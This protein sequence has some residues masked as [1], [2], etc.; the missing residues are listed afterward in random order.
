MNRSKGLVAAGLL[1]LALVPRDAG[2]QAL[3]N[4]VTEKKIDALL[5]QMTLEEKVGQLNQ[6]SSPFDVTG[7]APSQGAQKMAYEQIRTG[8]VGSMLNVN[9]AEATRKAQQL[10]VENSRLKIPLIFGYD[11]IH[12]YKTIF[13][14]PLGEAASWDPAAVERSARVAATEAAAAGLHWTFGPMVD[15]A[16]D[17]R[18]GRIMEGSGEDPFLGSQMAAARVRGFQGKDLAA[19]D[20]IA[21]CAKHYAAY[22]FA[23]AG[24]DYNTVDISESTLRNVVLPPFKAAADAGAATFMN[25]FNEI[26]GIPTTGSTHLQRDILKGEWGF[27]GFVVSD[28]GSIGEMVRHGFSADMAEAVQ[29]AITAGS[30]MDMEARA[31]IGHLAAL[32]KSGKVDLKLVDEAVRRVLRVKFA[33]GL[34]DDPYRYSDASREKAATLT[35]ANLAASRD[36]ARRS[37]VLLKNDAVLPLDKSVG[38]IA[39]IGPLAD[40]KDA[41]LGNW[42]GQGAAD[43]AVSLLEG[44]KAAVSPG[45]KVLYAE[46]TKLVT[47]PRTF[48]APSVFNTTDRSGFPAAVEAAR[49]AD[50]VLLAIGE[51]AFQTGE[52]RSQADIGL[53]GLQDEL[54]RAVIEANKKVVVVLMNGR[55]LTIGHVAEAVPAVV[56]AWLLGSQSGHAIADVLFGDYNPS[57]KL[58][59]SFPR[60]VGQ[61]PL[62]YG[63]K[64][65]GRPG[66]EEGVTWSHYTDVSNDPLYPFGF[67]LSY[68]SFTYSAP[69]LSAAEIGASGQLQVTVTVTNS[70]P[71]AGT[72]VVQLYVRDLVG[73]VTRPVKELKGFERV[74]LAPGQARDVT[75]TIKPA[76]LAFYTARGRWEAEPGAFKVF[77]GGN[78]RDVKEAS[79]TLR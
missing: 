18:W 2:A 64:S 71:R 39:V 36:V 17:A 19:L 79:F 70:G 72:E 38:S 7:P 29:Q 28:W 66:P 48:G 3:V 78:S 46:G 53:K 68:T 14:I 21:A 25:S 13:P 52:G 69:R 24:R 45:T 63:H 26:G 41:P 23:E 47:G 11:V 49:S 56:E 43:S 61:E 31:Y 4:P 51:D 62:Y 6:Y 33:L 40:D 73:S 60:L 12:G 44:V 1:A 77:V 37:I 30:D 54:F 9:G 55:P 57:G 10:A 16:R 65:T 34:F 67:G 22:G 20:T 15:I 59:V 50:V 8:L 75:F 32:V 35:P 27:K 58:P 42:R 74:E 5:A 76:D